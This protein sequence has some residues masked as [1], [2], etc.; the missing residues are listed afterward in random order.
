MHANAAASPSSVAS[1]VA[2]VGLGRG[3]DARERGRVAEQRRLVR[4]QVRR[5][6]GHEAV[7]EHAP[8]GQQLDGPAAGLGDALVDLTRLLGHVHVQRERV[9][10]GV[11][12]ELA[13]PVGG[14]GAHAVRREADAHVGLISILHT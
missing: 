9:R 10:V 13:Q 7:R 4:R 3:A 1:T 8:L 12:R 6:H 2:Q 5:V 11:G 14:H